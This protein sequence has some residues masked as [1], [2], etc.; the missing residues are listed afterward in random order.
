MSCFVLSLWYVKFSCLFCSWVY[1]IFRRWWQRHLTL[2]HW[3]TTAPSW[4]VLRN[5]TKSRRQKGRSFEP[6]ANRQQRLALIFSWIKPPENFTHRLLFRLDSAGTMLG[7]FS[8][9]VVAGLSIMKR[10]P[11]MDVLAPLEAPYQRTAAHN[12]IGWFKCRAVGLMRGH[13]P[14]TPLIWIAILTAGLFKSR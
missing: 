4:N 11:S 6:E 5:N 7:Q 2:R 1:G 8:L 14:K 10:R 13:Q 3:T 9:A 12:L